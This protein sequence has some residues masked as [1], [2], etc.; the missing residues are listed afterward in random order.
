MLRITPVVAF[1]PLNFNT[2]SSTYTLNGTFFVISVASYSVLK[3]KKFH[4][5]LF[6]NQACCSMLFDLG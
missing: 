4:Q 6:K 2:E 3:G 5:F 1:D